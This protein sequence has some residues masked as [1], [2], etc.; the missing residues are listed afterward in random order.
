MLAL[1]VD[2]RSPLGDRATSCTARPVMRRI[3]TRA[4]KRDLVDLRLDDTVS[5]TGG[6]AGIGF[7]TAKGADRESRSSR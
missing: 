6:T 4:D 7:A 3:E 5:L 1:A 2:G